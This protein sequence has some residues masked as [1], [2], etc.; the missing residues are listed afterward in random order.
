MEK[1]KKRIRPP[2]IVS[3]FADM[4]DVE[5]FE[6]P[7]IE[8]TVQKKGRLAVRNF[9]NVPMAN[10]PA[11]MPKTKL[12]FRPADAFLFDTISFFTFLLVVSSVKLDSPKLDL[13]ALVSGVLW[14]VRTTFRYSNKLARYDLLVKTFLT[15]K[16]S[17]RNS[18]AIKYLTSEAGSQRA[19]RAGLVHFWLWENF[20]NQRSADGDVVF[21]S[22]DFIV[23]NGASGINEI[24]GTDKQID[25]NV[26]NA[27]M[28][29]ED[30]GL[31]SL[32]NRG[33]KI[34]NMEDPKKSQGK[35]EASWS[36]LLKGK[37]LDPR[38]LRQQKNEQ[39]RKVENELKASLE[40]SSGRRSKEIMESLKLAVAKGEELREKS[41]ELRSRLVDKGEE[42]ANQSNTTRFSTEEVMEESLKSVEEAGNKIQTY[43]DKGLS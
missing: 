32:D 39:T 3:E 14:I 22:I 18:G 5:G 16:I 35:L 25:I 36:Q 6:A 1:Q 9:E 41:N 26:L 24:L 7:P 19:I 2:K 21:P 27:V 31:V 43:I 4:F 10:L 29:L 17:H 20:G 8:E 13:L 37:L 40:K 12:V 15:S 23:Q 33:M 28:D 42:P 34:V 11:V 30:L 38:L